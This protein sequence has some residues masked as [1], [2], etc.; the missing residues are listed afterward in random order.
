[1]LEPD[2]I[3]KSEV[4]LQLPLIL[5]V[6]AHSIEGY[7]LGGSLRE[8][9]KPLNIG[10]DPSGIEHIEGFGFRRGGVFGR[11]VIGDVVAAHGPTELDIVLAV[12]P[13][14]IVGELVASNIASL[15]PDNVQTT[16]PCAS[17]IVAQISIREDQ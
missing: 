11:A 6:P 12:I 13:I 1:M 2:A 3:G 5:D 8:L 4:R 7:R 14:H 17:A 10:S 9:L 15:R 16:R